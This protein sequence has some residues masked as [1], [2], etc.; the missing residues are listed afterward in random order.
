[1]RT[2]NGFRRTLTFLIFV[3]IAALFWFILALNDNIQDDFEVKIDIV[4]V[5][6]SVTFI[7]LPPQ[8][9]HCVVRDKGTSLWQHGVFGSARVNLDFNDFSHD[10]V[11]RV[12]KS[13][14]SADLKNTFGTNA[15]I[16]STSL[17]SLRLTYTTRPGKR[18]PVV[19]VSNVQASVG[20]II[21]G[22]P[23]AEPKNVVV[24]STQEILDT[25]TRVFTDRLALTHLEESG[26][27]KVGIKKMDGLRAD[28]AVV[29]VCVNVEPL[30][31]KSRSINVKI[32]HVPDG[33]DLLLFPSTV[34]VEYYLPMSKFSQESE[35]EL[36]VYVD[37]REAAEGVA[38]L[39]LHIGKHDPGLHNLRTLSDDVE[40]TVVRN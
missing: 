9:L 34:K 40:F 32:D 6:D 35:E 18:V 33:M 16:L 30:V 3:V 26:E 10:G 5:P 31:R 7:T 37:Y 4:N 21:N 38:R 29:E 24:Y 39:P 23:L 27:Y 13:E 20:K 8:K 1:M 15:Q 36:E 22:E 11:F 25:I 2:T 12:S 19:V 14:L 17:D 28:P